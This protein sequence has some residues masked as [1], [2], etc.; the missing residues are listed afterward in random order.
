MQSLDLKNF[1]AQILV[2][3]DAQKILPKVFKNSKPTKMLISCFFTKLHEDSINPWGG[4][5]FLGHPSEVSWGIFEVWGFV[6]NWY[7]PEV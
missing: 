5:V 4:A 1:D 6:Q 3:K 2:Q 7:T